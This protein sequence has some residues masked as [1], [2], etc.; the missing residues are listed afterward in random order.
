MEFERWG[1][2]EGAAGGAEQRTQSGHVGQ[3]DCGCRLG[4]LASASGCDERQAG[5]NF[6]HT[7]VS[8]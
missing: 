1:Q 3:G 8:R 6:L 2:E 7:V 5:C 4:Q